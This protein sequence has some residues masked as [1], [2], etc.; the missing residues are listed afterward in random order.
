MTYWY[1]MIYKKLLMNP[2]C[3]VHNISYSK[4]FW[5]TFKQCSYMYA[6]H[7]RWFLLKFSFTFIRAKWTRNSSIHRP[8]ERE[9]SWMRKKEREYTNHHLSVWHTRNFSYHLII[10]VYLPFLPVFGR[11]EGGFTSGQKK[12]I[13][14]EPKI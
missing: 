3:F 14:Y 6:N 2:Y 13:I 10:L 8:K 7:I 11:E 1:S 5:K 4:K 9:T 12:K